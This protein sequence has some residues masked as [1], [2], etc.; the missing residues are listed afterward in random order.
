M[1]CHLLSFDICPH[2]GHFLLVFLGFIFKK[3]CPLFFCLYSSCLKN[4]PHPSA[5]IERFNP[6]FAFTL[7]PGFIF[8]PF[9]LF[10]MFTIFKS[11]THTIAWFLLISVLS[12]CK[13][14]FR[15]FAFLWW[16]LEILFM[17]FNL[18]FEPFSLFFSFF[19]NTAI[20]LSNSVTVKDLMV[21]SY[22]PCQHQIKIDPLK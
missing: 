8:V 22:L 10:V 20:L 16:S 12:L 3:I 13:W 9:A 14:S 15:M 11:S 18:L 1:C 6:D 19:C 5:N 4:I 21:Y 7:Y 17:F 2:F